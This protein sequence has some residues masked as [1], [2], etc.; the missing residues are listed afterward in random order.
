VLEPSDKKQEI[1]SAQKVGSNISLKVNVYE[2]DNYT[3][4][5][6]EKWI[7]NSFDVNLKK[8]LEVKNSEGKVIYVINQVNQ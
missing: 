1:M 7:I 2:D 5:H 4:S 8:K 6:T 3:R